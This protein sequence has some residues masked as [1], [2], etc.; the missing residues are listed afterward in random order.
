[1]LAPIQPN[2]AQFSPGSLTPDT[3]RARQSSSLSTPAL[4]GASRSEPVAATREQGITPDRAAGT[5]LLFI[6]NRLQADAAAGMSTEDLQSRLDAGL[7]GFLKGFNEAKTIL[8]EAGLLSDELM[9]SIGA[10]YD[11]VLAGLA[12]MAEELGLDDSAI[13][14]AQT[15]AAEEP[16]V[17]DAPDAVTAPVADIKGLVKASRAFDFSVTTQEGDKVQISAS[18][19]FKANYAANGNGAS[20]SLRQGESF[21]LKIQGDLNEDE[22]AAINDLLG[23]VNDLADQFYG[24]DLQAAFESALALDFDANEIA[25]F[26]LDL[27]QT[28]VQKVRTTYGQPAQASPFQPLGPMADQVQAALES[29]RQFMEPANLLLNILDKMSGVHPESGQAD[30]G[31]HKLFSDTVGAMADKLA[32]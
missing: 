23:Q 28:Q 15:P 11:K 31:V 14:A 18:S 6:E 2:S 7:E 12:N 8:S 30:A 29:A 1:M 27:Q 20:A 13:K 4:Q 19:F 17:L 3:S 21:Q 32:A 22:L 26:A 5:I 16:P 24:G 9:A 10:T 25:G